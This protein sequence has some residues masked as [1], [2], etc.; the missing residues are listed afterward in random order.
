MNDLEYSFLQCISASYL[1]YVEKGARSTAK[2]KHP[3]QWLSDTLKTKLG[4][5]YV[6]HS[7]RHDS[8]RA[9][10]KEVQGRYY[11]K[12]VDIAIEHNKEII[13]GLGFKFV[14]SNYK[15][16]SN[17][18]FENL[19]GETANLQRGHISYGSL[20]VLPSQ[21]RYLNKDG[22]YDKIEVVSSHNLEKYMRLYRDK[23][24]PHKPSVSGIIFVDI[25]YQNSC[26]TNITDIDNMHFTDEIKLF[27]ENDVCLDKFIDVFVKQTIYQAAAK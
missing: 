21:I 9:K 24:F 25:D 14:T 8:D 12:K 10:E 4:G 16:N 11:D 27:L 18:Y 26:V 22:S 3:H 17:N 7:I 2:I 15:Q 20:L 23:D 19:L 1:S 5:E 13:S 6:V